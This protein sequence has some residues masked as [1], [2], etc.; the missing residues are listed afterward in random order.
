MNSNFSI[1]I[2]ENIIQ[3]LLVVI[4]DILKLSLNKICYNLYLIESIF[5]FRVS[6]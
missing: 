2:V 1:K 4:N 3:I 5:I 6:S